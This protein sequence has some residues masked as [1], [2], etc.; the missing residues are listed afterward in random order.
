MQILND[1]KQ[2]WVW[3]G[4]IINDAQAESWNCHNTQKRHSIFWEPFTH[5]I[6][7]Q[8]Y[9]LRAIIK[10]LQQKKK[11]AEFKKNDCRVYTTSLKVL[12]LP[13]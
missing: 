6:I 9:L 10:E 8:R 7:A 11:N 5:D 2:S 4:T 3:G 13:S 1:N 12:L